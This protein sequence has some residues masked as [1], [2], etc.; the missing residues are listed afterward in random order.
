MG[1]KNRW[2]KVLNSKI[3][4]YIGILSYSLYLWQQ[5]YVEFKGSLIRSVILITI[6][7]MASY[8]DIEKPF[9]KL[10]SRFSERKK[11]IYTDHDVK[12]VEI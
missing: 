12:P 1:P 3:L 11:I 4:N 8:Y 2:H 5:I 7:A 10:K 9:L 6:T